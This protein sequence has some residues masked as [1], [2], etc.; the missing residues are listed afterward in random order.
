MGRRRKEVK[1]PTCGD[2]DVSHFTKA[3]NR[4]CGVQS[5]CKPCMH[6]YRQARGWDHL[7]TF[8]KKTPEQ[9]EEL[10]ATQNGLCAICQ[11]PTTEKLQVDHDHACCS[12]TNRIT[13]GKCIRGLLCKQCNRMLG[14]AKDDPARL[15]RA[16]EY[17]EK[18]KT[19]A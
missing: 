18:F 3:S 17:L 10:L 14:F 15:R 1:C 12:G 13:C 19:K 5:Y 8:Y 6:D 4:A 9:I 11:E 2:T 16:A 7:S